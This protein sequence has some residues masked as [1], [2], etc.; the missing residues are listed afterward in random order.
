MNFC[1]NVIN[2]VNFIQISINSFDEKINCIINQLVT[3]FLSIS[4]VWALKETFLLFSE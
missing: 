4:F 3:S 1:L 2:N